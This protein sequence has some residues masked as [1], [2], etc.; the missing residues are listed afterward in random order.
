MGDK[1]EAQKR[2]VICPGNSLGIII[3]HAYKL[4]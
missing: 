3:N 2:Q 4:L 1:I